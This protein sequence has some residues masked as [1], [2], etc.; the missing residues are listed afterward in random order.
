MEG[1]LVKLSSTL[2]TGRT[3]KTETNFPPIAG[4]HDGQF[5]NSAKIDITLN[6][7]MDALPEKSGD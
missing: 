4:T 1:H 7:H 2:S 3:L 5:A 6:S